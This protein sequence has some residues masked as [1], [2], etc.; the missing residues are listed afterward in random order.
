MATSMETEFV[1]KFGCKGQASTLTVPVTIPMEQSVEDLTGRLVKAHNLP[2]YVEEDLSERLRDFVDQNTKQF[3]DKNSVEAIRK[4]QDGEVDVDNL[5]ERWA[6]AFSQEVK[7]YAKPEEITNEQLFSEVYHSLIH[8]EALETLL[9]LEHTYAIAVEDIITQRDRDLAHLEQRQSAEMEE[10]VS[11]LGTAYSDAQVNQLAQRQFENTQMIDSKWAS[12][13]SNQQETQKREYREWVMKVHEDTQTATGTPSFVQRVRALTNNMPDAGDDEPVFTQQHRLEESFTIHLGAQMKTMHNLRLL[14]TDILDLCRHK[15]HKVGGLLIPS[16]QRL[17]TAMSLYSNNLSALVLLVD[18]R[19]NSYTGMKRE[20]AK[21]CEQSSD[22]HFPD[23]E[24]QFQRI[25]QNVIKGNE[26]RTQQKLLEEG[27]KISIKSSG[28]SG[29]QPREDKTTK[30]SV[31]DFY[32]TRHSNLSDVHVA[33]HLV[34][35]ET[36]NSPEIS[37]RHPVILGI[38]N[39]LKMCFRYDIFTISIPLL[40]THDM[41]EEMTMQWCNRRA[42]L[43]FKCVKGFM[44]EMATWGGSDS[45]TIQFIVPRGCSDK[46][47]A[48]FS[49]ML[50]SIFRTSNPIK[51]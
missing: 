35:D 47:F 21:V 20:F 38:R 13:L 11:L 26:W 14:C 3:Y 31:G 48:E 18:N 9:N 37:S 46:M 7:E 30:M 19:L 25:E 29:S 17:Q 23:L 40:L 16:P 5:V 12:E 15:P 8:S 41:S 24:Q 51:G 28:S 43:V 1:F 32:I 6:K 45:R 49:T 34:T 39:I 33:F 44:M 22:F 2:C 10:A 42:E 36:L 27:D 4:V 50:P